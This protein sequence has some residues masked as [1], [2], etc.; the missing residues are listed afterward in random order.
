MKNR[1]KIVLKFIQK[2]ILLRCILA[3]KKR[4]LLPDFI[5]ILFLG[6]NYQSLK[7]E[8][9]EHYYLTHPQKLTLL[10]NKPITLSYSTPVFDDLTNDK[11]LMNDVAGFKNYAALIDDVE[12]IGGSNVIILDSIHALYDTKF[13]DTKKIFYFSDQG[14]RYYH[15]EGLLVKTIQS[16]QDIDVAIYLGGNFSWNYYHFLYEV[17]VKFQKINELDLNSNIPILADNI[18]LVVPQYFELLSVFNINNR[19]II[20]LDKGKRYKVKHLYYFSCP[21]IIPPDLISASKMQPNDTLFDLKIIEYLRSHLLPMASIKEFPKRI[22]ISRSKASGRRNFNEEEVFMV[23]EKY[24]FKMVFPEDYSL[25]DQIALFNTADFIAGGAGAAF[26]NLLFCKKSA[27]II[28]F[29]KKR[30][31]FSGFS[32]LANYV[33]AKLLCVTEKDSNSENIKNI[34]DSFTIDTT[35]LNILISEWI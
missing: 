31:L 25:I 11:S 18:S 12:V 29:A 1:F 4:D 8:N 13:N 2:S 21:N 22:F 3:L 14:I 26:A 5:P 28:T 17:I 9:I 32:T 30:L 34:H 10:Y 7:F 6:Y 23:F 15:K 33:G 35:S 27:K 19:K 20:A 16:K 24:D